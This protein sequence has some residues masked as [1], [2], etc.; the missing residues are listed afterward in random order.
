MIRVKG[1]EIF[2]IVSLF[3]IL[4][5]ALVYYLLPG[6]QK[7]IEGVNL[8]LENFAKEQGYLGAFLVSF[9]G[10]ATIIIVVP[11]PAFIF[12]LANLGLNPI[13]LAVLSGFAAALSEIVS[14][15]LGFA[16][17]R[18][19]DKYYSLK[20]SRLNNVISSHPRFTPF[21]L[22]LF[23]LTPLPDDLLFIPLGLIRYN[24]IKAFIP[25]FLGRVVMLLGVAYLGRFSLNYLNL[26]FTSEGGFI[27]Q[28]V[29]LI[30]TVLVIYFVI[31]VDWS[32]FLKEKNV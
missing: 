16:G 15:L 6:F 21:I 14:Y 10:A 25:N 28:I 27:T 24:F 32:K 9:I 22:F 11:Y 7:D 20:F 26:G 8:S 29:T 5:Y 19:I 18:I 17:G 4:A 31:K 2:L 12:I 3:L 30:L 13:L 1:K 23:G